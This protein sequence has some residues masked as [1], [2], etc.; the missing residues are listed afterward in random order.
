MAENPRGDRQ[1]VRGGVELPQGIT[2]P[3]VDELPQG[4]KNPG[5]ATKEV[6]V[7]GQDGRG[8]GGDGSPPTT[9]ATKGRTE[10]ETETRK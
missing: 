5:V 6:G 10:T 8:Q 4:R 3:G 1:E 2:T 9:R 7:L